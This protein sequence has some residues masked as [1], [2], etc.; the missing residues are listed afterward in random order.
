MSN[1][2]RNLAIFSFGALSGAS[3]VWYLLK[4]YYKELY[5]NQAQEEIDSVKEA[6]GSLRRNS[7]K[8]EENEE[9]ENANA[10]EESFK[11]YEKI[12]ND[13][14]YTK[15]YAD[16]YK[17]NADDQNDEKTQTEES[18]ESEGVGPYVISPDEYGACIDYDIITLTYYADNVLVD[19]DYSTIDEP[20]DVV[21]PDALTSFGDYDDDH[22]VYVCN[23]DLEVYYEIVRDPRTYEEILEALPYLR[24]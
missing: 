16:Y 13:R 7:K 21:G 24:R 22:S 17:K 6:Y 18:C 1:T 2:I 5:K 4:N 8:S 11:K 23:D 15:E 10:K 20:N 19:E 9:P 3:A 14:Q 12:I